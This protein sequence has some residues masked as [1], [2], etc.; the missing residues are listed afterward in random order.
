[1]KELIVTENHLKLLKNLYVGWDDT[2]FGAPCIDPKRPFGN[3]NVLSDMAKILGFELA[4]YEKQPELYD[5]QCTS[6]LKSYHELQDCLQILISNLKIELG[7]YIK[8]NE[9]DAKSWKSVD[10]N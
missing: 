6:L 3:S 9:Y 1:M 4:D 5:K 2:E 8:E 10:T 7:K